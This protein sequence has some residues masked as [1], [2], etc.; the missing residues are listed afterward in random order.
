MDARLVEKFLVVQ[1]NI[2]APEILKMSRWLDEQHSIQFGFGYV[3]GLQGN[4]VGSSFQLPGIVERYQAIVRLKPSSMGVVA[5][6]SSTRFDFE[7]SI[8]RRG[9]MVGFD[10]L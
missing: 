3:H 4:K 9:I 10:V 5:A 2:L 1:F 7:T 8:M 6:K